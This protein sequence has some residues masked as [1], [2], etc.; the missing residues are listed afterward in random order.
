MLIS[1]DLFIALDKTKYSG[2]KFVQIKRFFQWQF[3]LMLV[4]LGE[5]FRWIKVVRGP[6]GSSMI[7]DCEIRMPEFEYRY[8]NKE[9][10]WISFILVVRIKLIHTLST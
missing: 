5:G 9:I 2:L 6:G 8:W 1:T 7:L 10:S 4:A 3:S